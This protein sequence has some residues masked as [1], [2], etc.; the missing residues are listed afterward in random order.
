MKT[1][2]IS[3]RSML[4]VVEMVAKRREPLPSLSGIY[5]VSPTEASIRPIIEDFKFKPLYKTA[6]I[7]FSSHV[8]PGILTEI[9]N[10]SQLTACL[11]SLKEVRLK[12]YSLN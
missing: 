2:R 11:K 9:R 12:I 4:A 6:H 8:P 1:L 5:F 10:C 3:P 7:F